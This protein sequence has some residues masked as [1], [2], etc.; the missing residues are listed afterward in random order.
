MPLK[1]ASCQNSATLEDFYGQF[2]TSDDSVSAELGSQMLSLLPLL[3]ELCEPYQVWG[4]TSLCH[5]W[6]LAEDDWRSSWL[7][8]ISAFPNGEYRISYRTP[9]SHDPDPD[10]LADHMASDRF[11]ACQYI[12]SGMKHSGGWS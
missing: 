11:I 6:L 12:L 1:R 7:V 10:A 9:Q 5:L 4:L 3:S 8:R 2:A